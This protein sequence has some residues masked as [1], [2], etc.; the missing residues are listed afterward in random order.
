MNKIYQK[1][2]LSCK[3]PVKRRLGGF[4]LI[5]LLVVVL[6]IG[7]LAGVAVP[8]YQKAV[9]KSRAVQLQTAVK[10]VAT[11][12]EAHYMANG[13]YATEYSQLDVSLDNLQAFSAASGLT[14]SSRDAVRGNNNFQIALNINPTAFAFS[15]GTFRRG[16]TKIAVSFIFIQIPA[17]WRI[18]VCCVAREWTPPFPPEIFA[19][20]TGALPPRL[21]RY[22]TTV[23]TV[24]LKNK[25]DKTKF[26]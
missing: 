7:I 2:Y 3:N 16:H 12:Q 24:C 22:L 13:A 17:A 14:V 23:I 19:K 9:W 4:T 20:C 15:T 8:Q 6:I 25:F 5:E 10:S 1:P 21:P 11:A 18:K 26:I